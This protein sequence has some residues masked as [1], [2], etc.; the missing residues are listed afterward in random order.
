MFLAL[1]A[2]FALLL[3]LSMCA[4]IGLLFGW[5]VIAASILLALAPT[6][7]SMRS[8]NVVIAFPVAAVGALAGALALTSHGV[9]ASALISLPTGFIVGVGL[10][11]AAMWLSHRRSCET[12]RSA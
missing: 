11:S 7:L 1:P 6:Y 9:I 8:H 12:C 3:W 4:A 2:R 10:S 5:P